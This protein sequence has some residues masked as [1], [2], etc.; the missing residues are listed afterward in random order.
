MTWPSIHGTPCSGARRARFPGAGGQDGHEGCA[1]DITS[2]GLVAA[3]PAWLFS[4]RPPARDGSGT[5]RWGPVTSPTA[6]TAGRGEVYAGGT[7]S[8]GTAPASPG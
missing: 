6:A 8:N 5:L 7:P 4:R 3:S 2:G 1:R